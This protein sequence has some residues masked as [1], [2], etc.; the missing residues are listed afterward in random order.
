MNV[1]LPAL[2]SSNW[3]LWSELF[4]S[5]MVIIQLDH[6]LND[7]RTA[8]DF[9]GK[10]IKVAQLQRFNKWLSDTQTCLAHM[11]LA[12]GEEFQSL[13]SGVSTAHQAFA[14]LKSRMVVISSLGANALYG[15][16]HAKKKS[17]STSVQDHLDWMNRKRQLLNSQNVSNIN[18]TQWM[19]VI[20]NSIPPAGIFES[21][22]INLGRMVDAG[23]C[24][25]D[26][27]THQLLETERINKTA[28]SE[29]MRSDVD[30]LY[31]AHAIQQFH[32]GFRNQSAHPPRSH[33][34]RSKGRSQTGRAQ[35]R[36]FRCGKLGHRQMDCHSSAEA[37]SQSPQRDVADGRTATLRSGKRFDNKVQVNATT[38]GQRDHEHNWMLEYESAH[39][40]TLMCNAALVKD[41]E[42][43]WFVD[44]AAS[45]HF[46]NDLAMFTS[47]NQIEP[48][49]IQLGNKTI[50][51]ATASGTAALP[52][53]SSTDLGH[54]LLEGVLF[55]ESLSLNLVS[56]PKLIDQGY[57]VMFNHAGCRIFD[58]SRNEI[59]VASR[60]QES[61]LYAVATPGRV[62]RKRTSPSST[63]NDLSTKRAC[64]QSVSAAGSLSQRA[65]RDNS[66]MNVNVTNAVVVE[67]I[68]TP[69]RCSQSAPNAALIE[70]GMMP[71][72]GSR[73]AVDAP[74]IET[75]SLRISDKTGSVTSVTSAPVELDRNVDLKVGS[76]IDCLNPDDGKSADDVGTVDAPSTDI[77]IVSKM[78]VSNAAPSA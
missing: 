6:A 21:T 67:P 13:I 15:E 56:I 32:P 20:I 58:V 64:S 30:S 45:R 77:P 55:V 9:E 22:I 12:V 50:M 19:V 53:S 52:T 23:T 34:N 3:F 74:S 28:N 72:R 11:R 71:D 78:V 41:S 17:T 65:E 31:A 42:Q 40:I 70:T 26:D 60:Q 39:V 36:C 48:I 49:P 29:P 4:V 66:P 5:K 2:S 54:V 25:I 57:S 10:S 8:D 24:S 68:L 69:D 14:R 63:V 47:V 18:D 35:T 46:C 44:S 7:A 43:T 51:Y 76:A 37:T 62:L 38:A 59:A 73:C 33:S 61:G 75:G 27:V 1:P 16:I